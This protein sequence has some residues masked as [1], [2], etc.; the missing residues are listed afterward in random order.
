MLQVLCAMHPC[1]CVFVYFASVYFDLYLYFAS[2]Y[3]CFCVLCLRVFGNI[4]GSLKFQTS[5][6]KT[7]Q[8][9]ACSLLTLLFHFLPESH[10]WCW[11]GV[12]I[13]AVYTR[14]C[15]VYTIASVFYRRHQC[16][17][18]NTRAPSTPGGLVWSRP[19]YVNNIGLVIVK[20]ALGLKKASPR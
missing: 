11:V 6:A 14:V 8:N 17:V 16:S 10:L 18:E 4:W 2:V 9:L 3:L 13:G 19:H 7:V 12:H 20:R 5:V 1:I 15:I